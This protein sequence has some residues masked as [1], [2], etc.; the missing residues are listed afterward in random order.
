MNG[1]TEALDYLAWPTETVNAVREVLYN[2]NVPLPAVLAQLLVLGVFAGLVVF[3][4][5]RFRSAEKNLN[6]LI[7]AILAAAACIAGIAIIVAWIDYALVPRSKQ[8]IGQIDALSATRIHIDLLDFR[9]ETLAQA[10]ETDRTGAFV[11]TYSPEF[12]DPPNAVL[13]SAPGCQEKR[14]QLRR[15]QLLGAKLFAHLDCGDADG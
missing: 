11:I 6:R 12:A 2:L 7:N 13:I 3:F 15:S 1:L 4:I 5:G 8:I 14:I 10:V 9:G